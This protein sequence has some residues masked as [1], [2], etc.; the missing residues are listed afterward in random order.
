MDA[1]FIQ[2]QGGKLYTLLVVMCLSVV[3]I[4]AYMTYYVY[5]I[6]NGTSL[7]YVSY[8]IAVPLFVSLI[9]FI[10]IVVLGRDGTL[11]QLISE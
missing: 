2:Q 9:L 8:I 5:T 7:I 4:F 6:A 1:N 3:S 10:L 11:Q